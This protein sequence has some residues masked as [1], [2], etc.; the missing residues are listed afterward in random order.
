MAREKGVAMPSQKDF[1]LW[2]ILLALLGGALIAFFAIGSAAV[3]FSFLAFRFEGPAA[4][5]LIAIVFLGSLLLH[6]RAP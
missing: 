6:K 3:A 1:M 2:I 5:P 4:I